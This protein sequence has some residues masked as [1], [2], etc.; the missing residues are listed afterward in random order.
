VDLMV[1][2]LQMGLQMVNPAHNMNHMDL[3]QVQV[4]YK[5]VLKLM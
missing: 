5:Q 1:L 4:Q 3:N 2:V